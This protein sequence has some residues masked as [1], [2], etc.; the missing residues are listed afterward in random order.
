MVSVI[1]CTYALVR[2]DDLLKAVESVQAQSYPALEI[3]VVVDH[4]PQLYESLSTLL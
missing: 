4:N 1:I 3:I 2:L